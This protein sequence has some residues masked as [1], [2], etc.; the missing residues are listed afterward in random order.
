MFRLSILNM[1]LS[2]GVH[3]SSAL[4][5]VSPNRRSATD[6]RVHKAETVY[7]PLCSWHSKRRQLVLIAAGA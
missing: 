4:D 1:A 5:V 7:V 6:R 2:P 3:G